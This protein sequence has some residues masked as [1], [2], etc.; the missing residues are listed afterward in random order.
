[1]KTITWK[2]EEYKDTSLSEIIWDLYGKQDS[3]E[4]EDDLIGEK[5]YEI[6]EYGEYM[7]AEIIID[8]NLNIIGGRIIPFK[9]IL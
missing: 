2:I 9:T 1:M 7:N 4:E 8:E 3:I 5:V 6:F